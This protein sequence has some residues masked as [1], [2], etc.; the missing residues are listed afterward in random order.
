MHVS[1]ILAILAPF[2]CA[3]TALRDRWVKLFTEDGPPKGWVVT[4]W[5]DLGKHAPAGVEWAV[6]DGSLHSGE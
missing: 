2:I 5:N 6:K 4:E 3:P 1:S